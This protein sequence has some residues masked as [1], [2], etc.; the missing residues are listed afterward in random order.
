MNVDS[1]N[2]S[3]LRMWWL[4]EIPAV[5]ETSVD[6]QKATSLTAEVAKVAEKIIKDKSELAGSGWWASGNLSGAEN[7]RPAHS[8]INLNRFCRLYSASSAFSAVRGFSTG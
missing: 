3:F 6:N 5:K 4:V 1:D 7:L 8:R 2:C